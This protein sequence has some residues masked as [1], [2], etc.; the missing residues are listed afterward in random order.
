MKSSNAVAKALKPAPNLVEAYATRG[1]I[2]MFHGWNWELAEADFRR[3]IDLNPGF[4]TALQWY[5]TLLMIRQRPDE[6][7]ARLH[8]ALR[9]HPVSYNLMGDPCQTQYYSRKYSKAESS[10]R[11]ALDLYPEFQFAHGILSSIYFETGHIEDA[12]RESTIVLENLGAYPN[13][14]DESKASVR[15][16]TNL[17]L[18]AFKRGGETGYWN[19]IIRLA[20]KGGLG[21]ASTHIGIA[22]AHLKLNDNDAAIRSLSKAVDANA[23]LSP[24]INCDPVWARVCGDA[25][26]QQIIA[27]MGF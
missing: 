4:A 8:D 22:R 13:Q 11:K 9:I 14:T 17:H 6:A 16:S 1:F 3:A 10:C 7:K 26:F 2:Y 24:F 18:D 21:D 23:F 5:A 12:I 25:R 27:S 20:E 15:R 19:F